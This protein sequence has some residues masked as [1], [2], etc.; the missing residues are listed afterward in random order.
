MPFNSGLNR[1]KNERGVKLGGAA[2]HKGHLSSTNKHSNYKRTG[3]MVKSLFFDA[4]ETTSA[5][6]GRHG[7]LLGL[8]DLRILDLESST[9]AKRGTSGFSIWQRGRL[10]NHQCHAW[11]P[12]SAARA[13][14]T[15][16]LRSAALHGSQAWHLLVSRLPK[17]QTFHLYTCSSYNLSIHWLYAGARNTTRNREQAMVQQ[18]MSLVRANQLK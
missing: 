13:F 18:H 2:Q 1:Q 11:P 3:L 10:R 16:P 9:G 8:L 7:A 15:C 17:R 5:L 12:W 6:L 14:Q 4:R